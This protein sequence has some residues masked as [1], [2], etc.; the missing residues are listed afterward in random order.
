MKS[1]SEILELINQSE[2]TFIKIVSANDAGLTGGHQAGIYLPKNSISIFFDKPGI[3]GSNKEKF[4]NIHW[5]DGSVSKSR[6]IYYGK[7]TRNEYRITRL[8]KKLELN[9]LFV[10]LKIDDINFEGLL[11]EESHSK[12]F[13]N[14]L[15]LQEDDI[16]K[17]LTISKSSLLVEEQIEIDFN[18]D[19]DFKEKHFKPKAHILTLLGEELIKSP[20]MAIYELIKN[21]YDADAKTVNVYFREIE[22]VDEGAIIVE[23]DGTGLTEDVIENVWLEPGSDF[24]KPVD[25][26]TG[27][28]QIIRSPLFK[29]VPMGEKGIGRFA[30]HK[31][32]R[33]I[34]LITRPQIIEVDDETKEITKNELADYEIQLYINWSEFT[35][36]KHLKD[37]PVKWKVKKNPEEFRFKEKSGTYIHLSG[38]K[39]SWNRGMSRSLKKSTLS[40]LSPKNNDS[41]FKIN[42]EFGNNWLSNFPSTSEVLNQAPYKMTALLDKNYNLTF[43][44]VFRLDNNSDIGKREILN[45]P[46]YNKCVK[47]LIRPF[48][49]Q[50]F[51]EKELDED[52]INIELEKYDKGIIPFGDLMIEFYSYDL[53]SA[54]LKDISSNFGLVKSVLK[55]HSGVKVFKDDLRVYN[56]GEPG[57]DW[58][59][60]DLKRVNEKKWFSNNQ[61]IG[62]VYLNSE[63]SS[64]LIE[65]TN[66]EGFVD[67]FNYDQFVI[68]I[69]WI[70]IQF[71][72]ERSKDR[73]VWLKYN[74]KSSSGSFEDSVNS[75]KALIEATDLDNE[76]KK[77]KLLAQADKINKE[78]QEKQDTLLLPAGVGLTASVALHEIDKLVPRME[79]TVKSIPLNKEVITNQVF[80]LKEYLSGILSM[81]KKGGDSEITIK[82]SIYQALNNYETKLELRKIRHTVDIENDSLVIICD[83]RYF[84]TM[85]MNLIDN[86][87]YWLDSIYSDNKGIYISVFKVEESVHVIFAD[88]GPGFSDSPE[89]VVKPFHSRKKG[90]IG[91]GLYIIDTLMVKYGKLLIHNEIPSYVSNRIPQEYNGAV[92]ELVFS[93]K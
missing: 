90:G 2:E 32:S 3:K 27:F 26:V 31:L 59:G 7:G 45:S 44:Y 83:R 41:L 89:E 52:S 62:Y 55:E 70:L 56:Y 37:I 78:F 61:N 28:R 69:E 58:L 19:E 68:L 47:G 4:I 12:D 33:K 14:Q 80:E 39:E 92:I 38:L 11:I 20:V 22:N 8:D 40:M 66:R 72:E 21:S 54:S 51:E 82:D 93:K 65:K 30:V 74:K 36:S 87:I 60:L 64:T 15:D 48:M 1:I 35:Q 29:R 67:S 71:R 81:L 85:L 79:E 91:L 73:D 25:K 34:L 6:V 76:S 42:L 43:E 63:E 88:N 18:D 10:L 5:D 53:D 86:S 23:D 9:N 77:R 57:N 16:T 84:I 46:N 24:R 17:G 75:F 49:R 13:L 50:Y